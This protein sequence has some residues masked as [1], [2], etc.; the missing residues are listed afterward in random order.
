MKLRYWIVAALF[1]ALITACGTTPQTPDETD[2]SP[3]QSNAPTD[4]AALVQ[5]FQQSNPQDADGLQALQDSIKTLQDA[6]AKA[7][8][9]DELGPASTSNLGLV[10]NIGLGS[11]GNYNNYFNRRGSYPQLIW[12]RDGCSAPGAVSRLLGD[13]NRRF[14]NA[15]NQHDFAYWNFPRYAYLDNPWGRALADSH[16]YVNMLSICRHDFAWYNPKR[17]ACNASAYAYYAAVRALGGFF[18]YF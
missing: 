3:D 15:C 2:P 14:Y 9:D 10:W 1:G 13:A 8:S 5:E 16:F 12:N 11:M 7:Q 17:Y 4:T 18:F 6:D